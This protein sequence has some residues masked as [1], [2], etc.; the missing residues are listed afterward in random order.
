[1][2]GTTIVNGRNYRDFVHAASPYSRAGDS[3][4]GSILVGNRKIERN[5][6]VGTILGYLIAP[7]AWH[8]ASH[9]RLVQLPLRSFATNHQ[10]VGHDHCRI[11][12]HET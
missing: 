9:Q 12:R 5:L 11:F 7:H 8:L 1:M 2:Q 10:S 4:R 3:G 6:R